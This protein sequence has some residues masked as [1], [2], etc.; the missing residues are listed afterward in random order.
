PRQ[1]L[2]IETNPRAAAIAELVIW[3]GHLQQHYRSR[4]GH[5]QEPVLRAFRNI[6][7][8]E[9]FGRDALLAWDGAPAT[10]VVE[11]DGRR[12]ETCPNPRRAE[13]PEAEFIV[14]NPP[15]MG[16]KDLR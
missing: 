7:E 1:F 3:I 2:G 4:G 15:F 12:V 11:K 13:W 8:G 16:G 9:R 6:N 5:P 14:G 10:L